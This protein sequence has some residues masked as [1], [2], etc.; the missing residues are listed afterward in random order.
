ML[1]NFMFRT[2]QNRRREVSSREQVMEQMKEE[3]EAQMATQRQARIAAQFEARIARMASQL[4]ARMEAQHRTLAEKQHAMEEELART[5]GK[6]GVL[7]QKDR[8]TTFLLELAH[9]SKAL[10]NDI[11]DVG[12]PK[13]RAEPWRVS[14]LKN[15]VPLFDK[16]ERKAS[17]RLAALQRGRSCAVIASMNGSFKDLRHSAA[18]VLR[19]DSTGGCRGRCAADGEKHH[20]P[21]L[22]SSDM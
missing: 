7:Q 12:L 8:Y 18:H 4:E 19:S 2:S 20:C 11:I 22:C 6:L 21:P 10:K 13:G 15:L 9:L 14:S 3:L 5:Q 16:D 1:T 17:K